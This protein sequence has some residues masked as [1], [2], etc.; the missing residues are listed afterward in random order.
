ML[1]GG[2]A[3]REE[4]GKPVLGLDHYSGKILAQSICKSA[5]EVVSPCRVVFSD[6]GSPGS[7]PSRRQRRAT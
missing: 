7:E 1:R 5:V 6:G 4:K 2:Y 3:V